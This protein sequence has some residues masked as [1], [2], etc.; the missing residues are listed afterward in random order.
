MLDKAHITYKLSL[1]GT[2]SAHKLCNLKEAKQQPEW[3][4][5]SHTINNKYAQL[6]KL[7]IFKP[8]ELP[9]G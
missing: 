2:E 4:K 3:P 9:T 7:S 1:V 8:S 6:K 5:W